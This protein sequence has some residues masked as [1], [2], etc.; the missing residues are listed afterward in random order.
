MEA[1]DLAA[2]LSGHLQEASENQEVDPSLNVLAGPKRQQFGDEG[3]VKSELNSSPNYVRLVEAYRGFTKKTLDLPQCLGKLDE[4]IKILSPGLKMFHL[5]VMQN[6]IAEMPEAEQALAQR[7][8][9]L[10]GKINAGAEGMM[11]AMRNSDLESLKAHY[12]S[13]LDAFQEL[14][15]VQDRAYD[16]AR[17][18]I[19]EKRA[20]EAELGE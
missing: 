10:T 11:L 2:A 4:V 14:D 8:F 9:E 3:L 18:V 12:K 17:E 5:P 19:K 1:F 6:Q 20:A 16:S 13:A 15:E 7:T